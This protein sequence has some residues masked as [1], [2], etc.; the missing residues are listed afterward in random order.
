MRY[1]IVSDLHLGKGQYLE[2]GQLNVLEDFHEDI[3]FV[4]F[5]EFFSSGKYANAPIHLILNGDILNLIQID[6][7][8][9]YSHILSEQDSIINLEKIIQGHPLFFEGLKKFLKCNKKKITYIIGNHDA[10]LLW[11]G[12]QERLRQEI[13]ENLDIKM[14]LQIDGIHFE[15]GQ[16]FEAINAISSSKYFIEGPNKTEILN[17]PW[18]SL[19]CILILSVLK[20]D[21][22]HIDKVRPLSGYI[23]WT[24]IHDFKFFIKMAKI[25]LSYFYRTRLNAYTKSNRNFFTS[26][27]ILKSITIFPNYEKQAKRI[28]KKNQHINMVI[29]GHTHL[30]EWRKFP[31]NKYYFNS[32]TWNPIP[33]MNAGMH[34]SNHELTYLHIHMKKETILSSS[35]NTWHGK[36]RPFHEKLK[37]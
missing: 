22:P 19:F 4:E 16:R 10:N 14:D 33:S 2:N 15:H 17:L 6:R 8:G 7:L 32:G 36:W 25:V 18:G 24:I 31:E 37:L 13:G 26:I 21:R 23:R 1:L 3:R 20:K 5:L 12:P 11:Q 9:V 28:L 34:A 27:G 30:S 29:M 35:I